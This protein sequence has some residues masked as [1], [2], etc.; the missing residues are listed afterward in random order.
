MLDVYK[1]H[2][3]SFEQKLVELLMKQFPPTWGLENFLNP[4]RK[5]LIYSISP[6]LWSGKHWSDRFGI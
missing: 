1:I 5:S 3:L 6:P 4:H 2:R